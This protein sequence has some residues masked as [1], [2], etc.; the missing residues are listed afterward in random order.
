M[1]KI[2]VALAVLAVGFVKAQDYDYPKHE[3]NYNILNTMLQ[4]S[5]ELGYEYYINSDQSIGGD[6]LFN[7]RFSYASEGDDEKFKTTSIKASY[8]LYIDESGDARGWA[9]SPFLKY[10]FGNFEET[11]DVAGVPTVVKTDMNSFIVGIGGGYKIV[12]KDRG[13]IMPFA[14]IARNFSSE[15]N[16]RFSPVEFNAGIKIGYR[17]Y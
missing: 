14:S 13:T 9:I 4:T 5:V 11:K 7:D 17:F 6:V 3:I 1:K 8:N 10:R 15:V 16:D 12:V 2:I